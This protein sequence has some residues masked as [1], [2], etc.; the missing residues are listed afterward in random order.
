MGVM[1]A[2]ARKFQSEGKIQNTACKLRQWGRKTMFQGYNQ[3]TVDFMWGIRFNN[4][5]TWFADHKQSYLDDFYQPTKELANQV[6]D[7]MHG[8]FPKEP[9]ICK[10]S[11]IYRDARRLHGKGP[12]K[13]HLWF[14][15][16]GGDEDWTGKPTFWFELGPEAYN[17]GLG[18]WAPKP[19]VMETYRAHIDADPKQLERLV[20]KFNQQSVF[21]LAGESYARPKGDPGELLYD[22]YQKKNLML[23]HEVSPLDERIFDAEFADDLIRGFKSLMPF[24]QYLNQVLAGIES[25]DLSRRK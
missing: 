1:S 4:E 16:R 13:D 18:F 23:I 24:Y 15:I 6:F 2:V 3:S 12:Y 19:I 8:A 17:Y 11:R 9:M 22:W 21:Q 25:S 7:A 10:V 5:R 14:S 20:R